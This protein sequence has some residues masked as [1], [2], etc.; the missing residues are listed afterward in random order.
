MIEV[1]AVVLLAVSCL[2]FGYRAGWNMRGEQVKIDLK[3][4]VE[5]MASIHRHPS[6]G[7]RLVKEE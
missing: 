5:R 7:L 6:S 2:Y 1:I 3:N 4:D